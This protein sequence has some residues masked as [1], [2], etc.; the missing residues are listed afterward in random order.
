MR[1][2]FELVPDQPLVVDPVHHLTLRPS[3]AVN[4]TVRRR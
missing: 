4:V 1:V 2:S 3:G